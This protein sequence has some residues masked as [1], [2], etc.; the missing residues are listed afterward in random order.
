MTA[1]AGALTGALAGRTAL[2]TG[3]GRGIGRPVSLGLARGSARVALVARSLPE[4]QETA[5]MIG[6]LGGQAVVISADLGERSQ[7]AGV[8]EWAGAE[9]GPVDILINNAA[10]VAP[11][12]ASESVN[13][14]HWAD[15]IEVNV[16]A[17]ATLSLF[18][19][20]SMRSRG[21]GRIVN[22]SSSIAAHPEAKPGMNAYATSKAALEA[23]TLNLAAEL[24]GT[25]IT[26][27]AFQPGSVDTAV[28]A[29]IRDQDPA[30]IGGALHQRFTQSHEAGTLITAAAS[31][32]VL[33]MHLPTAAT[34]QIWEPG[35]AA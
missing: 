31:A 34:G 23:H 25:E 33:L 21:W 7:L 22:V 10:V 17:P 24:A 8:A 6:E 29:W 9:L 3:A 18:L 11:L 12:G 1:S 13:S 2:V 4:L 16:I 27:S 19:L 28:Q 15:A 14:A 30:R 26:V 32:N 20:A 35:P 5:A